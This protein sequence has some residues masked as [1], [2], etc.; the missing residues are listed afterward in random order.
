MAEWQVRLK[1]EEIDLA[2]LADALTELD[3]QVIKDGEAYYLRLADF[4]DCD[5][6]Q[7][8]A[9]RTAVL[10]PVILGAARVQHGDTLPVR[11]G[12][13][14]RVDDDGQRH[15]FYLGSA[16]IRLRSRLLA[17]GTVNGSTA[18][19]PPP[20][21]STVASRI[22]IARRDPSVRDALYFFAAEPNW[23]NLYKVWEI[24]GRDI[25]GRSKMA[26]RGWGTKDQHDS[27]CFSANEYRA[28]GIHARH[29]DRTPSKGQDPPPIKLEEAQAFIRTLL[30]N[31]I[32]TK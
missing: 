11:A 30:D 3:M 20:S 17:S 28:S 13:V 1:G 21:G 8:V 2:D 18:P 26:A 10:M 32:R 12:G 23:F 6:A 19:S 22:E 25:G 15:Y 27:F 29:S 16:H 9:D 24:I 14:C 5:Q 31:W 4:Q 7:Q